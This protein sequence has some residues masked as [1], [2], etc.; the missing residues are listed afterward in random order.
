MQTAIFVLIISLTVDPELWEYKGHFLNCRQATIWQEIH[1]PDAKA[2][3][4]M[5]EEYIIMP[6]NINKRTFDIRN[7]HGKRLN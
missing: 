4:C 7:K 6:I 2:T 5:L 1:Y 3:K